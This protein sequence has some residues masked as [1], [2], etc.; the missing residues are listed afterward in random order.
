MRLDGISACPTP[1]KILPPSKVTA[2][3]LGP[4]IIFFP[5]SIIKL[6]RSFGSISGCTPGFLKSV[7]LKANFP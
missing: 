3:A 7:D 5:G 2:L 1:L 4:V 6:V